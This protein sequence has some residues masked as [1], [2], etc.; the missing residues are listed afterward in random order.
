M[1]VGVSWRNL[2]NVITVI[3]VS[4]HVM[5]WLCNFVARAEGMRVSAKSR[6]K[7]GRRPPLGFFIAENR[8][9]D[10]PLHKWAVLVRPRR[11]IHM[12][13]LFS[14]ESSYRGWT[15]SMYTLWQ[16]FLCIRC[17]DSIWN[18]LSSWESSHRGINHTNV[19]TVTKVWWCEFKMLQNPL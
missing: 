12:W 11:A 2:I 3:R 13:K 18:R 19:H 7:T 15:I 8:G 4:V 1:S 10:E 6:W 14:L 9:R 5:Y 17:T 16:R